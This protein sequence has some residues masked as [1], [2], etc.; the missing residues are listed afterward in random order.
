MNAQQIQTNTSLSP[1]EL[2]NNVLVSGCVETSNVVSTVNGTSTGVSSYGSFDRGTSNFPFQSGIVIGTGAIDAAGTTTPIS[3]I[4]G[5]GST[6]WETDSDLET[7]LGNANTLNATSIEFD[8]VSITNTLSFNYIFASEEY[9]GVYPCNVDSD[10]FVFLIKESGS[11]APYTNIAVVPG[12]TLPVN[13][14]NIRPE[15]NGFCTAENDQYFQGYQLGDTNF[16]GRTTVLNATTTIVPYQ[17]Y[18]IKLVIAD[19][20]DQFFDSAVF[21][22]GN[23]FNT[24]IDL[25]PDINTCGTD[26]ELSGDIGNH[27]ASYSW[28]RNGN[29]IPSENTSSYTA[30]ESGSYTIRAEVPIDNETCV[31][32]DTIEVVLAAEQSVG[33]ISDFQLC[34][35]T[36]PGDLVEFFDLSTKDNQILATLPAATYSISYHLSENDAQLNANPILVP[37]EN[38]ANPQEIFFRVEDVNSGCLSFSSFHI[39]VT[40]EL[41]FTTPSVMQSCSS[42]P[43]TTRA[44]ISFVEKTLEIQN[45]NSDLTITYHHSEAD[46]LLG[47]FPVNTGYIQLDPV[48]TYYVRIRDINSSCESYTQFDSEINSTPAIVEDDY[49]LDACESDLDGFAV[50]DLTTYETAIGGGIPNLQFTYHLSLEEALGQSNPIANPDAFQNT[51]ETSQEIFVAITDPVTS[52]SAQESILLYTNQMISEASISDVG[53]CDDP[54][55]DGVE[56]FNLQEISGYFVNGT[57][58]TLVFYESESDRAA[59][60]NAIDVTIPYENTDNPQTIY[61]QVNNPTC[62]VQTEFRLVV[63]GNFELEPVAPVQVCDTDDDGFTTIDLASYNEYVSNEANVQ[64]VS[65]FL[66]ET[67][68]LNNENGISNNYQ[69]VTNPLT[70]YARVTNST[71]CTAVN[72]LEI[73]VIPAPTVTTPA[74]IL[75]CDDDQD[76]VSVVDLTQKSAEITDMSQPVTVDYFTS[77][78]NAFLNANPIADPGAFS[79]ATRQVY[80]RVTNTVTTCYRIVGFRVYVNTLPVFTEITPYLECEINTDGFADFFLGNKTNEIRNGQT[81][82]EVLYFETEDDANNNSNALN[83]NAAYQNTSNPQTIFARV[84]NSTDEACYDVTSFEIVVRESAQFTPPSDIVVCDDAAVDGAIAND[85]SSVRDEIIAS[86][87]QDLTVSFYAT[88]S[89]AVNAVSPLPMTYTNT[90]NPQYI[91]IRV[92]TD[93]GCVDTSERFEINI[94]AP[95]SLGDPT[96]FNVCDTDEDGFSVFDL[97]QATIPLLDPRASGFVFEYYESQSDLEMG[98]NAIATPENYTNIVAFQ[99]TLYVK[100]INATTTCYSQVTLDLNVNLP[101]NFTAVP[102]YEFCE[103]DAQEVDMSDINPLFEVGSEVTVSYHRSQAD[104]NNDV[105]GTTSLYTYQNV[106]E[107]VYVRFTD[108]NSGCFSTTDFQL[109]INPNPVIVVPASIEACDDEKIGSA[110]FDLSALETGILNGLSTDDYSIAFYLLEEDAIQSNNSLNAT[111]RAADGA[112]IWTKVTNLQTQCYTL[113]AF[114]VIIHPLPEIEATEPLVVCDDDYDSQI[115]VDLTMTTISVT[116]LQSN[117]YTVSYFESLENLVANANVLTTPNNVLVTQALTT[118]YVRIE[119]NVTGCYDYVPME[120]QVNLP[121]TFTPVATYEFCETAT[122]EIDLSEVTPLFEIDPENVLL[123]YYHSVSTATAQVNGTEGLYIYNAMNEPVFVR[124]TNRTTGCFYVTSF[125]LIINPNPVIATPPSLEACDDEENGTAVFDLNV[126]NAPILNGQSADDFE[127][128]FYNSEDQA[129]AGTSE[130]DVNYRAADQEIIWFRVTNPIT[131][132]FT[133]GFTDVIIH[134]LPVSE[135]LPTTTLCLDG[136]PIPLTANFEATD[137]YIWSTGE[138]AQTVEIN[139]AGDYNVLII[140]DQGCERFV[141]FTITEAAIKG[142]DVQHFK[143]PN[144]ATILISGEGVYEYQL[145]D[146][147]VQNSNVFNDLTADVHEIIIYETNGCNDV[148][149]EFYVLN[150]PQYFYP[151]ATGVSQKWKLEGLQNIPDVHVSTVKIF[152]RYGRLLATL[153]GD[154]ESWDGR[155]A[156]GK[157]MPSTDYWF[158]ADVAIKGK[159]IVVKGNFSLLR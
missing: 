157:S 151:N 135:L 88:Q 97:T 154:D 83:P 53:R 126:L 90:T 76:G 29:L 137:S 62:S 129:N 36:N 63:T 143:H 152:D 101:P 103:N 142:I 112:V 115:N 113:G 78:A 75:I 17:S 71:G 98:T 128:T 7:I 6:A 69:N 56:L 35:L 89:N 15:I 158:S 4:L 48:K 42:I 84:Q 9:D 110:E 31:I 93:E 55:E 66:N 32:E 61:L 43:G 46:A 3:A 49:E 138:T 80:A 5:A 28:Y 18:H 44:G 87:A 124:V 156:N 155:D 51:V 81:G 11:A 70:V 114:P 65:Y 134:P 150:Y 37:I 33:P 64:E 52:C 10:S 96:S 149:Q 39:E 117:E 50:F 139:K 116:N 136:N 94:L 26:V 108:T 58:L 91:Y 86:S 8:F 109:Q 22:E 1:E 119:N 41:S 23:S 102:S 127:I 25:G 74:A 123:E 68:A 153:N 159:H 13:I 2:I 54:S 122:R 121:P 105:G 60:V 133:V 12:T 125:D 79:T 57:D 141:E 73:E 145:D 120:V 47:R 38:T 40:S 130:L 21:I 148:R 132:C 104:A 16:N 95:P 67:D 27:L 24:P 20:T 118:F 144:S 140:S 99:Q 100:V 92:E 107:T 111:H 131:S 77:S 45:G 147:S 82:K 106:L 72:S 146:A 85:L 30:T 14:A 59:G 19:Q 34:D